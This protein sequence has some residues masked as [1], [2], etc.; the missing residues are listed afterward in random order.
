MNPGVARTC[1]VELMAGPLHF[2]GVIFSKVTFWFKISRG[3]Q[4]HL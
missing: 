4:Y 3:G 2:T 1:A